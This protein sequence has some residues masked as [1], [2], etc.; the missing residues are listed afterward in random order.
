M[1]ITYTN[2][3]TVYVQICNMAEVVGG[4]LIQ[5]RRGNIVYAPTDNKET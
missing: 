2:C 4:E 1:L 5:P 3:P